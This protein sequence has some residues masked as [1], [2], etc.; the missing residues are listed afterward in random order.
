MHQF[1]D[2]VFDDLSDDDWKEAFAFHPKI[3]DVNSLRMRFTGNKEWSGAEQAGISLA[4][5]QTIQDLA[6]GNRQYETRFGYIFIVCASGKSAS[7]M[8][9]LLNERLGNDTDEELINAANE[10]RKI[11]HRRIDKL[12]DST[13]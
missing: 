3:G 7:E 10:Q 11:S 1:A 8:L 13:T 4:D 5:E 2:D 6:L 9:C 12:I